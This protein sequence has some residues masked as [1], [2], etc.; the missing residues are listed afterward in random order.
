MSFTKHKEFQRQMDF[1]KNSL[2]A[3]LK[4]HINIFKSRELHGDLDTPVAW[5]VGTDIHFQDEV[6]EAITAEGL[7][8]WQDGNHIHTLKLEELDNQMLIK[9]LKE[10]ETTQ[11]NIT[12]EELADQ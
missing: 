1:M 2:I 5:V 3:A 8:V 10:V 9:V 7:E 4:Q 12:K 6:I 11:W